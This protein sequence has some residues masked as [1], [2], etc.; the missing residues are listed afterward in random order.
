VFIKICDSI[1]VAKTEFTWL[2]DWNSTALYGIFSQVFM[3]EFLGH[4]HHTGKK[5]LA[6]GLIAVTAAV[7]AVGL[8]KHI[9]RN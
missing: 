1:P 2:Q 6:A 7:L 9:N 8:Y 4:H 3:G 5:I